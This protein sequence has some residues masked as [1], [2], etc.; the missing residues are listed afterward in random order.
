MMLTSSHSKNQIQLH[1]TFSFILYQYLTGIVLVRE[2]SMPPDE[3]HLGNS[4]D[5]DHDSCFDVVNDLRRLSR[6]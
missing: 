2:A 1:K 3:I 4:F 5:D 6:R